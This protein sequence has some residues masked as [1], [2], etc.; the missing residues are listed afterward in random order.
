MRPYTAKEFD[1]ATSVLLPRER[2]AVKM[3]CSGKSYAQ[4]ADKAGIAVNSV[5]ATISRAQKKLGIYGVLK[6]RRL[7]PSAGVSVTERWFC[8]YCGKAFIRERGRSGDPAMFCRKRCH[9]SHYNDLRYAARREAK[10]GAV[11]S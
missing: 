9:D 6:E 5:G 7:E 1:E 10:A 4:I 3:Y 2:I 11:K 8:E